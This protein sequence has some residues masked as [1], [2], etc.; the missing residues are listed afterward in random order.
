MEDAR[1]DVFG[2]NCDFTRGYTRNGPLRICSFVQVIYSKPVSVT[3]TPRLEFV[4]DSANGTSAA[5]YAYYDPSFE[6]GS[7][8]YV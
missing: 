7:G 2:R 4:L 1:P 5:T 3:G 6:I 8:R